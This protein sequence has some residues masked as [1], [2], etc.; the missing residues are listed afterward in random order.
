M[1]WPVLGLTVGLIM[2]CAAGALVYY[3]HINREFGPFLVRIFQEKP[4]FVVPRGQAVAD[5]EDVRFPTPDGITLC[6]CYLKT[7][8]QHRRGVILFGLEYGSN[9]WSCVAYSQCLRDAGYDIFAF[10]PRGQGDSD[11]W[12]GYEPLQWVT[13]HE[14]RDLLASLAY[15]SARPDADPR[16][17][18]L[19][20][21]SKGATAGIIAA[22]ADARVRCFVTDGMFATYSTMVPYMRKWVALYSHH[23][24]IQRRLPDWCFGIFATA[25]LRRLHKIT[26]LNFPSLER[27]LPKLTARPL[28]MIHGGADTYIKPEM[29]KALFDLAGGPREFWL[30]DGAR[31]NQSLQVANGEYQKRVVEFFE[32]HLAADTQHSARSESAAHQPVAPAPMEVAAP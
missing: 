5:A 1:S 13:E 26:G 7:H 2:A 16:G 14:I 20:A 29:A 3:W 19:F 17:V 10:E 31:H 27:A 24:W 8:A 28:L 4:L 11:P 22:A 6:G 32:R 25:A 21:I 15:L 18:G 30:V 12:P 9:R 23:Y